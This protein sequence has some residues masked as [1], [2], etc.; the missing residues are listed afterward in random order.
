MKLQWVLF[1]MT[2][3]FV[4]AAN[5]EGGCPAGQYPIGGQGVMACAPMPQQQQQQ[6]PRRPTGEWIKTWG[7]IAM[8]SIDSI[9]SYGVPTGKMSKAEA[10]ADALRRCASHGETDCR[11]MLTYHNQCAVIAEPHINGKPFSTGVV[12]FVSAGSIDEASEIAKNDC[13]QKNGATPEAQ[14]NVVYKA[15][16]EPVFRRY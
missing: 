16:S 14:C 5:A 7:S 6:A 4:G 10:E 13:Q 9:T 11:V 8:G 15:C 3:F 12:Q 2:T 1:C